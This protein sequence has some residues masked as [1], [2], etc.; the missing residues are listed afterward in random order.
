M[1]VTYN[2]LK[3][4]VDFNFTV[5]EL[6]HR[7]TMAGL[8]VDF[9]EKIGEGLD[10]VVVGRLL[11]VEAHP[12]ADRLTLCKVDVGSEVLQIVCGARN[13][14]AGD[15]VAVAQIGSVLPGDFKIK[16]SKIRG[17][18]SQGMLCSEK[19]LGLADESEGILLLPAGLP[20][21]TPVF[22]VLGLKDA[23]FELGL[24]PN[25]PDCLSVVGVA[26]EVAAMAGQ[27]LRLPTPILSA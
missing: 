21:G 6:S 13:H 16:K 17:V 26:R 12:E 24:T 14:R 7:L 10:S 25:R 22:T 23:R 27:G 18:E 4:F 20:L 11:A 3:E 1:I 8:E 5:E 2:W 19:E 15:Y 9:L